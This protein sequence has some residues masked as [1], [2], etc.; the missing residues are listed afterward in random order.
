MKLRCAKFFLRGALVM[1][2]VPY[3]RDGRCWMAGQS[4][5]GW[6]ILAGIPLA[7]FY[8]GIAIGHY[9]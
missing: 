8:A 9:L 1:R 3:F 4:F 6:V 2:P 5:A 7:I